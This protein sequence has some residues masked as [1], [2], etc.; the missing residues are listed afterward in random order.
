MFLFPNRLGANSIELKI[1]RCIDS[2]N[3]KQFWAQVRFRFWILNSGFGSGSGSGSRFAIRSLPASPNSH[4]SIWRFARSFVHSFVELNRSIRSTWTHCW[5]QV[6]RIWLALVLFP[7]IWSHPVCSKKSTSE[8]ERNET[9]AM[10]RNW[11]AMGIGI[12]MGMEMRIRIRI[13]MR[14]RT[15]Q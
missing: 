2:N 12:G 4:R 14:T 15:Q 5:V 3:S 11:I 6:N 13:R 7:F 8:T 1:A 9:N 10:E